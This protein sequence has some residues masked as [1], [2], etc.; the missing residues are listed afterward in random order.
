MVFTFMSEK[1]EQRKKIFQKVFVIGSGLVFLVM[2]VSP[3]FGVLGNK[4]S[5]SNQSTNNSA[6]LTKQ[7]TQIA[8]GY[9]AVLKREPNNVTALQGLAEA[10][11]KLQDF[12]GAIVPVKKLSELDPNNPQYVTVL[13]QLYQKSN[14]IKGAIQITK[15][16]EKLL[17][18][19]PNNLQLIQVL[20]QLYGQTANID[21]ISKLRKTVEETVKKEPNNPQALQLLAQMRLANNDLPGAIETMKKLQGFYPQDQQL[22]AAIKKLEEEANKRGIKTTPS[23]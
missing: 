3:L 2:M 11:I 16:V 14:D 7:L 21:G 6:A 8:Q 15:S 9:E 10:K 5:Q 12:K 17:Q 20:A 23:K 18:A 19:D 1:S 4:S 22:A 13:A